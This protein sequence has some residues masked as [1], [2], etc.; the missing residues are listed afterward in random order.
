MYK[1]TLD[2]RSVNTLK[3]ML[4]FAFLLIAFSAAVFYLHFK[5]SV[6][7]L[8]YLPDFES[9]MS[10]YV[11]LMDGTTEGGCSYPLLLKVGAF[12]LLFLNNYTAMA[13]T[14]TL[15]HMLAL[16]A[17]YYY[18]RKAIVSEDRSLRSEVTA[19]VLTAALFLVSMLFDPRKMMYP[20][21]LGVGTPNAFHNP[22]TIAAKPFAIA[23]FFIFC[24]MLRDNGGKTEPK[25]AVALAL[26]LFLCDMAKPSYPL[27][28]LSAAGLTEAFRLIKYRF[29]N[30]KEALVLLLCVL[31]TLLYMLYQSTVEFGEDAGTICFGVGTVW[32]AY[33]KN[34]PLAILKNSAFPIAVLAF[35]FKELKNSFSYRF[36]WFQ[37]AVGFAEYFFLYES[38]I[39]KYDGNLEWGYEYAMFFLFTVSAIILIKSGNSKKKKT[40]QWIVFALHLVCGLLYF[41][42]LLLGGTFG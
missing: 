33:Q 40:V 15:L 27:L 34:I 22:T 1:K 5:Q 11:R 25:D 12:F 20:I 31:P 26:M 21:Y 19:A 6:S 14:T 32:K 10:V 30:Y 18:V 36:A 42:K 4:L 17:E 29:R 39:R 7:G 3:G 28:F 38:G 9:D 8:Y 24:G 16:V 35:N 23:V 2:D 37:Y 41:R 13:A